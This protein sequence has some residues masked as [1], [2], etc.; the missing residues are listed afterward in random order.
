MHYRCDPQPHRGAAGIFRHVLLSH[1]FSLLVPG[2]RQIPLQHLPFEFHFPF[3]IF[4]PLPLKLW[5][6]SSLPKFSFLLPDAGLTPQRTKTV[7]RSR[8][9]EDE[10]MRTGGSRR[11]ESLHIRTPQ[12]H[13]TVVSSRRYS[14][15]VTPREMQRR[16]SSPDIPNPRGLVKFL[17]RLDSAYFSVLSNNGTC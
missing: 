13:G 4:A 9:G 3:S 16:S 10:S 2:V 1:P 15:E 8:A 12:E 11:F 6:D 17:T 14:L 7:Y 5:A